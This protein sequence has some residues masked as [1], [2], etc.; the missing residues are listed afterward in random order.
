MRFAEVH[1]AHCRYAGLTGSASARRLLNAAVQR[2]ADEARRELRALLRRAGACGW[3]DAIEV[4]G[5]PVDAAFPVARVAVLAS[6]W[7]ESAEPSSVEAAARR[8]TVL[9]GKGW[10][11]VHITWRDLM[12]RPHGVLADI[13]RHV[14]GSPRMPGQVEGQRTA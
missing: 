10:T 13:A 14:L 2:S 7:A 3:T 5:R 1:A 8:W 6:G 9:I 11:I 4:D 12:E